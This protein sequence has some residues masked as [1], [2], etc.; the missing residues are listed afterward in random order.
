MVETWGSDVYGEC[1]RPATLTN[2][3]A[4]AAGEYQSVAVTDSGTVVQWGQYQNGTNYYW[5]TNTS[6]ASQPPNT[7]NIVAVAA[8]L[9]R[10]I[11]LTT[12]GTIVNWGLT[13]SVDN[14]IPTNMPPVKAIGAGW[15]FNAALLTNGTVMAW[16]D[17]TYGQTNVPAG[18]SNITAIATGAQ[19]CLALSNGIVMAWG[20]N[21]SN[22]CTIPPNLTNTVA[23]AAGDSHSVALLATGKVVAW[24]NNEYGQ[25]NVPAG[26]SNVMAIAAGAGHSVA[27]INNGT[28]VAWG[29]NFYGESTVPNVLPTNVVIGIPPSPPQTNTYPPTIVKLIAAGGNHTMAAIF[30]PLVQYPIDVS[31][32]VLLIYNATNI[33]HSSN[34]CAYYMAHRPM[35]SNANFLGVSCSTNEIIEMNDYTNMISEPVL[36]WLSLNPTKRPQYVILFQDLPSRLYNGSLETSVQYDISAGYNVVMKSAEYLTT[37]TPLVTSINMDNSGG[38]NS[39]INYV[40][41]LENIGNSNSPGNLIIRAHAGGYANTN[42]YFDDTNPQGYDEIFYPAVV[43]VTNI[44]SNSSVTYTNVTSGLASGTL[45]GHITSATNVAGFGSWGCHGYYTTTNAITGTNG[46]Y[47]TNGTIIF[48]GTSGWFLIE[49]IE[50][51]NGQQ[52][53]GYSQGNFISWYATNAF[54]G[55]NGSHTPVGAVCYVDEPI[56]SGVNAPATYFGDWAA[57][58]MFAC[59]AWNSRRTPV[60]QVV[61]DPFTKQ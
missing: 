7:S 10:V 3:T 31:K 40:N 34:I 41:K 4:I 58:R 5:V 44:E 15:A 47:A 26:L 57:E 13:N 59:C 49:T 14:Y 21:N 25:T 23:I 19:H 2:T 11:A 6:I 56:E 1:N 8:G 37:W 12:N 20:R 33:S 9:D 61:G 43:A 30:S 35:M 28:M 16:G 45:A 17:N 48:S 54:G 52:A 42:W 50:S 46:G 51:F 38:S 18:L 24:G 22:Q 55:T 32:D 60:L 36:Q 53:N 29:N 27:L 39:C